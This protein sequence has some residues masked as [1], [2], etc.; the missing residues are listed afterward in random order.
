MQVSAFFK[1]CGRILDVY[2]RRNADGGAWAAVTFTNEQGLDAAL[3]MSGSKYEGQT[4]TIQRSTGKR[5]PE[6]KNATA[7]KSP[8]G[9]GAKEGWGAET[10]K[11]AAG[12]PPYAPDRSGREQLS[13]PA[14]L[15]GQNVKVPA[16]QRQETAKPRAAGPNFRPNSRWWEGRATGEDNRR[17]QEHLQQ[18]AEQREALS[19]SISEVP[20]RCRDEEYTH[21]IVEDTICYRVCRPQK[22][23][24]IYKRQGEEEGVYDLDD[25][26][27]ECV[28]DPE[29]GH[30]ALPLP[31][32]GPQYFKFIIGSKGA[33]RDSIEKDTGATIKVP[34]PKD[35]DQYVL[36]RGLTRAVCAAAKQRIDIVKAKVASLLDHTHF[37]S[38]PL[39]PARD[40]IARLIGDLSRKFSGKVR[41]VEPSIF[42][43]AA[44]AHLTILMLRLYNPSDIAKAQRIMGELQSFVDRIF[45][46]EDRISLKGLN[47]MNDDPSEV[48]VLYLAVGKN[49]VDAKILQLVDAVS[50]AFIA[51]GLATSNEIEHNEKL[52][53]TLMNSKWRAIPDPVPQED[54]NKD[55]FER[56][57]DRPPARPERVPFDIRPIMAEYAAV[58]LGLFPLTTLDLSRLGPKASSGYWPSDGIVRFPTE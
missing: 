10:A 38:L 25:E 5:P 32:I 56:P 23:N 29:T 1:D 16:R 46:A 12:S 19:D 44:Q 15:T 34:K 28:K 55:E 27:L 7:A 47:Y 4:L 6:D 13:I 30:W 11:P 3:R 52:H 49:G 50:Q 39:T 33:T 45:A 14:I 20:T 54:S 53:A 8:T 37:V 57:P 42:Q 48:H 40:D 35:P 24:V 41:G 31:E 51:A 17:W 9:S 21:V 22:D 43:T 58:D 26:E 36:I 2:V 18:R